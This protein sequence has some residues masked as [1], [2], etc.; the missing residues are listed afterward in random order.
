MMKA[1]ILTAIIVIVIRGSTS[2]DFD[3][4]MTNTDRPQPKPTTAPQQTM[5]T[6]YNT[7][8]NENSEEFTSVDA[9][10]PTTLVDTDESVTSLDKDESFQSVNEEVDS[11]EMM[12]EEKVEELLHRNSSDNCV[13]IIKPSLI[14]LMDEIINRRLM[15]LEEKLLSAINQTLLLERIILFI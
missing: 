9:D 3:V 6:D 14:T 11:A 15:E 12:E 4:E 2:I 5:K 7:S 10:E 8:Q 1:Y 13:L